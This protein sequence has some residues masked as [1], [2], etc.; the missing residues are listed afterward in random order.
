MPGPE[1]GQKKGHQ[2]LED[3]PQDPLQ[4]LRGEAAR[5]HGEAALQVNLTGGHLRPGAEG[6]VAS[7]SP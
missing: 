7:S 2:A 5:Q 3:Q 1:A 6:S 4:S